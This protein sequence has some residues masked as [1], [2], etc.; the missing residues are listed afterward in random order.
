MEYTVQKLGR[1]AGVSTRTLRYYDEIGLLEPAR[2]NS[3]GYRIYGQAEVDK[4]QQILFYRELGVDLEK[5]K[6]IVN[7]PS[8]DGPLALKEHRQQLLE[9][10]RQLD[11]LITNVEKTISAA[12]GTVKMKDIEKFKGFKQQLIEDNE[13]QYGE[14]IRGK[15]GD[16]AI[17]QSNAKMLNMSEEKYAAFERL[18]QEVLDT[19]A[20]AVET[21]DPAGALA[22]KT[23]ELHKEWLSY[24][25]PTYSKEAHAGLAQMY[26]DDERFAVYYDKA[27]P[28]GAEFLRDAIFVYTGM[29]K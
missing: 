29:N 21:G 18:G 8:F 3:S 11:L 10:R 13:K 12:E 2:K 28:G 16:A 20:S 7:D 5:I 19:L 6:H 23:A 9:K 14:E 4:L 17:D 24:T 22:Q 15:Y 1:L 25:W 26:V 27:N